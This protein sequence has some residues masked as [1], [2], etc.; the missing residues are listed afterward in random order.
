MPEHSGGGSKTPLVDDLV[1]RHKAKTTGVETGVGSDGRGVQY[2]K[3][4]ESES[5]LGW[6]SFIA[7]SVFENIPK[8][9]EDDVELCKTVNSYVKS[10]RFDK[11]IPS[12]AATNGRSLL[13]FELLRTVGWL[14]EFLSKETVPEP[15]TKD[16][17]TR[18]T[19][20][21]E[22]DT[23]MDWRTWFQASERMRSCEW[24]R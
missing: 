6:E 5:P 24:S 12:D 13:W 18:L 23:G 3:V 15:L 16:E 8:M 11:G 22:T 19:A 4:D 21:W 2:R 9:V 14:D 1:A 10:I 17:F 20:K 7:D